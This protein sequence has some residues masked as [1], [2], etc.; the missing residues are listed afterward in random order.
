M[1][2]LVQIVVD[3]QIPD[4]AAVRQL[5]AARASELARAGR[6]RRIWRIP[7][8]RA[9]WSI[10]DAGTADELHDV[11]S[12]LPLFPHMTVRVHPLAGH[13]NDPA[14][15]AAPT[16]SAT[17]RTT[18]GIPG[19][20]GTDHVGI[21]VP[22][23]EEATRFFV[24]VIGCRAF[25]DLG[26]IQSDG[27][28]MSTHLGVHPRSVIRRLRFLR[29]G[30]GSNLELFEYSAPDQNQAPPRNSDVGGHH[31]AFYVDDFDRA[32]SYL[33]ERGV[34]ILGEPT[35]RDQGPS[36]GLTWIYFQA[37]WGLQMELVSFPRGKGYEKDTSERLW[38]PGWQVRPPS[39]E[40]S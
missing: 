34:L 27:D 38:H 6:L 15:A 40:S 28:W 22:D 11:L 14:R 39:A 3:R 32:V 4:E 1:E 35:V 16:E 12:S 20:R 31:L 33:R 5:E 23:L 25:Y 26:P 9:S 18:G 29:C 2:F 7:G 19:L 30:N 21:T 8:E 36:A 10:W 17:W 37:P 24:E 13:P